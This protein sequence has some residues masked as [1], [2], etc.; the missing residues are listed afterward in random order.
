MERPD[1]GTR[2]DTL[3]ARSRRFTSGFTPGAVRFMGLGKCTMACI[4]HDSIM[5][6]RVF[7]PKNTFGLRPL[8]G[9]SRRTP[10]NR[11]SSRLRCLRVLGTPPSC[12]CAARG[13]L[14]RAL[15]SLRGTHLSPLH[16]ASRLM[17]HLFSTEWHFLVWMH[18][19][20]S[21]HPLKG[22]VPAGFQVSAFM[23][24]AAV[25]VCER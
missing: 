3:V 7:C 23:N 8:A 11:G 12:T 1:Q 25:N 4:R 20:L 13:L 6:N 24:T 2:A 18:H 15:P 17:L 16:V 21:V 14:R 22:M 10:G 19:H 9:P 5:K